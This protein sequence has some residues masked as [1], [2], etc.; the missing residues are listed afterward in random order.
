MTS[1]TDWDQGGTV[2][3]LQRLYLGPSV[4]WVN[5]PNNNILPV[6]S[7]GPISIAL[8]MTLV[9]VN[10]NGAVVLNLPSA[11]ASAAGAQAQPGTFLGRPI[12][13]VDIAGFASVANPITCNPF[14]SELI[15][16]LASI[17]IKV[18]YGA[19]VFTP[20]TPAGGYTLTQS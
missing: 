17:A 15:D 5:S 3:Q 12:V 11:L 20:N 14:G 16:G 9:T 10:F 19:V 13:V 7:A 1:Q 8:G 18:A 6:T 2:R 4:G